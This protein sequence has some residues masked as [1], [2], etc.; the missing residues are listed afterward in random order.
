MSTNPPTHPPSPS[1][2]PTHPPTHLSHT[3][4]THLPCPG[5]HIRLHYPPPPHPCL[6]LQGISPTPPTYPPT[7]F[8]LIH[9]Y[10]CKV[11]KITQPTHPPTHPPTHS[12]HP[13]PPH[14][15]LQLQGK[16]DHPTHPPTLPPTHSNHPLPP[17]PCLQLQGTTSLPPTHP[18]NVLA[19]ANHSLLSHPPTQPYHP[20]PHSNRLDLLYPPTHPPTHPPLPTQDLSRSLFK[21]KYRN[22]KP[23]AAAVIFGVVTLL[24]TFYIPA[25][26]E[27]VFFQVRRV[28]WWVGGGEEGCLNELLESVDGW[29]GGCSLF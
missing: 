2:P 24:P 25:V 19:A 15:C 9:A 3:V 10:N 16:E 23:L 13:L 11:K 26:D 8:L 28:G 4:R 14:P 27:Q 22:N 29:V 7:L 12:N 18:C 1:H 20:A 17:H 6:Q 21:M 5:R